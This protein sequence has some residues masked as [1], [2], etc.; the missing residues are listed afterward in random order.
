MADVDN[1]TEYPVTM[2][3]EGDVV[4]EVIPIPADEVAK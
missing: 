4:I 3:E 1:T 2:T